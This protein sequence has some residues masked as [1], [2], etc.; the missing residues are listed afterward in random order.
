MQCFK[1]NN[2]NVE[3]KKRKSAHQNHVKWLQ[4]FYW[5]NIPLNKHYLTEQLF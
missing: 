5:V 4:T 3:N 1:L 2:F